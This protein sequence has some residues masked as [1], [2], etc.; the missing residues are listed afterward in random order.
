[1]TREEL[2]RMATEVW[3]FPNWSEIQV[4][5]LERFIKMG[6]ELERKECGDLCE[7]VFKEGGDAWDCA[8]AIE[9]RGAK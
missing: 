4:S 9:E 3:G 1:M 8:V 7:R 2:V 5:R 6:I